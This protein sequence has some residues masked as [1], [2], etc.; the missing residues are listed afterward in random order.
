M[1]TYW[2]V[3]ALAC[4]AL[5]AAGFATERAGCADGCRQSASLMLGVGAALQTGDS[6]DARDCRPATFR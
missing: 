6:A 4:Y 3:L 2:L 1:N 5:S